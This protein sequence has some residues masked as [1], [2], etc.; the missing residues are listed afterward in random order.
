VR[1]YDG[2]AFFAFHH[3]NAFEQDGDVFVDTRRS[4]AHYEAW[5]ARARPAPGPGGLRRPL[6]LNRP[7]RPVEAAYRFEGEG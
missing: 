4:R 7:L 1:S 3:I 2:E 5:L 6:W